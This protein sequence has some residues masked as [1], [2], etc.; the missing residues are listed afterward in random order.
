MGICVQQ[1]VVVLLISV[2]ICF[3]LIVVLVMWTVT[4]EIRVLLDRVIKVSVGPY[5]L[6][7]VV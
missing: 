4:M 2:L 7:I 6:L 3:C 1:T 5:L